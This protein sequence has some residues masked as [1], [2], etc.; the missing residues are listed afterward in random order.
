MQQRFC[1]D[2]DGD[3]SF[4][5]SG[6]K[7]DREQP[8]PRQ[9][10]LVLANAGFCHFFSYMRLFWRM[11]ELARKCHWTRR[12]TETPVTAAHWTVT[13]LE[14][15]L[16]HETHHTAAPAQAHQSYSIFNQTLKIKIIPNLMFFLCSFVFNIQLL[17]YWWTYQSNKPSMARVNKMGIHT[18]DIVSAYNMLFR[19]DRYSI[20]IT[21]GRNRISLVTRISDIFSN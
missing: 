9:H 13:Q 3:M 15:S 8:L 2:G 4:V 10:R 6:L 21:K 5:K 16:E 12:N 11:V 1:S 7:L 18:M 19:T 20:N 17:A 14:M